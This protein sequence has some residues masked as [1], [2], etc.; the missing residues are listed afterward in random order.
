VT[1]VV[2]KVVFIVWESLLSFKVFPQFKVPLDLN[3][4]EV[5]FYYPEI[6]FSSLTIIYTRGRPQV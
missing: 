3:L 5:G 6:S 2:L 4:L 1:M